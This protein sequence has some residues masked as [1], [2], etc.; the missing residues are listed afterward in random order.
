MYQVHEQA[1][2]RPEN[3]H[4]S[5]SDS[6]L[7]FE[8]NEKPFA[9]KVTRKS[10]NEVLFDSS[11][12]SLVYETQY[13]RLRTKLP[14]HP[15]IYGLGEHSDALRFR[16]EDFSKT[17]WNSEAAGLPTGKPL[18]GSHPIYF[19]HRGDK[20]THGVFL[21]NAN[22]MD[23]KMERDD[24]GNYL[25]YNIIGGVLDF[26]FLA[27]SSPTEVSQQYADT[28]GLPAMQAY[29]TLGFQQCK[30]G[31]WDVNMVAEVVGNYSKA[32]IPLEVM[33]TDIDY[34]N[35]RRDFTLD[36]ERFPLSKMRELVQTLQKRNQRYI[37]I[38]DPPIAPDDNYD[39]YKRGKELDI[40]HHNDQGGYYLGAQW[41][42]V[43]VW[44]DWLHPDTPKWWS[45]EIDLAFNPKTGVDVDGL[46]IDMNEA[47]NFCKNVDCD[48]HLE[49]KDNPP[50]PH[51]PTRDNT[52]RRIEGFPESF[53]PKESKLTRRADSKCQRQADFNQAKGTISR[54]VLNP[55]YRINLIWPDLSS[56]TIYTNVTHCD[57]TQHYDTHS[58]HGHMMAL[59][60]YDALLK[61]R[62]SARPFVVTR[63]TFAGS[64]RKAAH[65]FGDN[66]SN[67]ENYRMSI[68]QMIAFV[69]MH[70]MP[71]VG[72][73]VCG[74]NGE[75]DA[76]MCARWTMLGAFQPF[77]RNH[78]TAGK[79]PQEAYVWNETTVAAHKAIGTRYR[80]LDYAYTHMHQQAV[81]GTPWILPLFF[82]YPHDPNTWGLQDQWFYGPSLLI[83]PVIDDYSDRVT[84]YIPEG[85]WYDYWT[86][87][88]MD[89]YGQNV[90]FTNQ[91]WHDIPVHIRG[92]SI[93]LERANSA[94]TTT[95]L[96]KESFVAIVAPDADGKATGKLYLDDG[97]SIEQ[98]PQGT[99]DI[100]FSWD[101]KRFAVKGTFGYNL[102][103][104]GFKLTKLILL[105][106]TKEGMTG[107]FDYKK[108][109]IEIEGPGALSSEWSVEVF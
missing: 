24:Q 48:V 72:S 1:V 49:S 75:A 12:A 31:Y 42:G 39:T 77:Y 22:G 3:K 63:S 16:T 95:Q 109:E 57:G 15:N 93:I 70:Q 58:L 51:S 35:G 28:V 64:G 21:L 102:E 20:G 56:K 89:S 76:R 105:G 46:W 25:E 33:W 74:F 71:M 90:T 41:A 54:N 11:V 103:G 38:L 23:V 10:N 80:L 52:G 66:A 8:I 82:L 85:R 67:W 4:A 108:K 97:E 2:P 65:W 43:M 81:D 40:F 106:Q 53:Q 92:G 88:P 9:F 44:P 36:P 91:K 87:A 83:S 100:E 30:Y 61:R 94:M 60:T 62:P 26:Y 17:L 55:K 13:I 59:A 19:D 98:M 7:K 107:S 18:Y 68:R 34:M 47:S 78:A 69:S 101:G 73:D 5:T 96:R 14:D 50:K 32:E 79:A 104:E 29:W 37:L 27:G 86:H 6:D 45:D 84:F 99:S